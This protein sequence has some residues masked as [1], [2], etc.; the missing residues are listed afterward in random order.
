MHATETSLQ[1]LWSIILDVADF[2]AQHGHLQQNA[3]SA[4]SIAAVPSNTE[5]AL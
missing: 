4:D 3:A 1:H 5:L 2:D